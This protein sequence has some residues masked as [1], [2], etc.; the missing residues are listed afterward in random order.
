ML[1]YFAEFLT[2][3]AFALAIFGFNQNAQIV[4]TL[5]YLRKAVIIFVK[6]KFI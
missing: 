2:I 1:Y 4:L 5:Y 6:H 3:C